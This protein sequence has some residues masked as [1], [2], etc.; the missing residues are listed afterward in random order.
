MKNKKQRRIM[1][2]LILLLA[3]T[4]GFALLSTTLFINGT[5]RIKANTWNIH[6]DSNSIHEIEGSVT[7]TTPA[8]VTDAEEKN[9]SFEVEFELP[10]E[11]YEFTADA[12][13][14]GSIDGKI[15]TISVKFYEAD[16]TT[17]IAAADLPDEITYSLT[18]KDGSAITENEVITHGGGK[19]GYKFRI[20]F[21]SQIDTL[22]SDTIVIKPEV[23]ITPIQHKENIPV[24][25]TCEDFQTDSWEDISNNVKIKTDTYPLGCTREIDMG[26]L[27]THTVRVSNNTITDE[28]KTTGFSQSACGFVLEF[29]DVITTHRMNPNGDYTVNGYY[30]KG[31]WEY[32]DMRA[33]VNST[34]YAA[35]NIDYSTDGI[36]NSLP[37]ALR[38]KIIDTT[39]VSGY[40]SRDSANFTTTDKL[41][42][43]S[44]HEV[45][46]DVDDTPS[47]GIDYFDKSY[48]NTKQL[49]YYKLKAVTTANFQEAIKKSNGT[50]SKWW[51]R[52]TYYPYNNQFYYVN[53]A[54]DVTAEITYETYG[55][56][57]AFRL[58]K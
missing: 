52:S 35:G 58:G 25:R 32:S 50:E 30:S 14:E 1:F 33:Y 24:A 4:V 36:F 5:S 16:G 40:A 55:I 43:L 51:L 29:V 56:S 34:T 38:S 15:E 13:N 7:A 10:G 37:S 48:S 28:C 45:W 31:G 39:V 19:I 26:T 3:V 42:L 22:P 11:Y 27:G 41:Y 57:P 47:L 46:E 12:I 21:D 53:I 2:L 6:W 23:E 44:P 49:D 17:E 9:I 18:H 54:G 8:Q 20:G